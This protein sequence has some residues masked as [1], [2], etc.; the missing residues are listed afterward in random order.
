VGETFEWDIFLLASE[1]QGTEQTISS[2]D[3]AFADGA[4]RLFIGT[5]GGQEGGLQDQLVV[6]NTTTGENARVLTGVNSDEVT[7]IT[8]TPDQRTMFVNPQHPGNGDPASTNF[9]AEQDGVTIPRDC[10]LVIRR[11]DGGIVGS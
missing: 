9:P 1:T 11:K 4:G 5:D 2:P 8:F 7:G 6:F 3:A 10:T